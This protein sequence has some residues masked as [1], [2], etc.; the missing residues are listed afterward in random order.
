M[1]GTLHSGRSVFLIGTRLSRVF[2]DDR[3]MVTPDQAH[4]PWSGACHLS[5]RPL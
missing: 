5:A 3:W 1:V 2:T 4:T